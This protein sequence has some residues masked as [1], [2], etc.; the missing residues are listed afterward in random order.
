[1]CGNNTPSKSQ[2]LPKSPANGQ[3]P[4]WSSAAK[5][6]IAADESGSGVNAYLYIAYADDA[7][8]NGFTTAFNPL[9]NYIAI[10]HTSNPIL[11]AQVDF[12]ELW[13]NYKGQKGDKGDPGNN[14]NN[15]AAGADG[16]DGKDGQSAFVYVGYADDENGGGFSEVFDPA[17]QFIAIRHT[18]WELD[19]QDPETFT[20]YWTK[21][22][23]DDGAAGQN[24]LNGQSAYVYIAYADNNI[25]AGFT[26][27][28]NTAKN[29]IAVRN[30]TVP[31]TPVQGDFNGLWFNY[32]GQQGNPGANGADGSNGLNGQSAY[33][34]LGYA[35]DDS[36]AGY[37]PVFDP[38]KQYIAVRSSIVPLTPVQEDF[39][40]LWFKYKG[41]PGL[42]GNPGADG[43]NGANGQSAY[44]Y[45]AYANDAGGSGFTTVFTGAQNFIAVKS[46][47][48]PLV[49]V[50][51][52]FAG[53]WFNYKGEPGTNGING[54]NG[55]NGQSAYVYIA[56][57]DS[58]TGTGF[59]T[60]F[61]AAK[62]YIAIKSSNVPLT[63]LQSDFNGLWFSYKGQAGVNG[64]DG[65]NGTN[66][67][68]G[69][70]AY[71]YIAYA[72]DTEGNGYTPTFDPNKNFIAMFQAT[73]P[74]DISQST[75][76]GLWVQ[77]K[78]GSGGDTPPF[79]IVRQELAEDITLVPANNHFYLYQPNGD[80]RKIYLDVPL[81]SIRFTIK[82]TEP[83]GGQGVL[84]VQDIEEITIKNILMGKSAQ[85]LYDIAAS[86]W[87]VIEC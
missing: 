3:V 49:P 6:W 19:G 24:G 4:K 72:D 40:G 23:G 20:G 82:N 5:A 7:D 9:K 45:I 63:P 1:M 61:N 31:L 71:L 67:L 11:P 28:F 14:G 80:Q 22:K 43:A 78:G 56:Y 60:A 73:E 29:F 12:A 47:T 85:I 86:K 79:T 54:T 74:T 52:D 65:L 44:V 37:T 10:K 53:L 84:A 41:E 55:L 77:Y 69:Q 62:N 39:A 46:S 51:G 68:N 18:T 34:Y 27:A 17:K 33:L 42:N 15:G 57:A 32:K 81:T 21:Y 8:G 58:N 26:T 70:N 35:D 48:V 66:G 2:R 75:F 76:D 64:A 87:E 25:G 13:F 30:S 83:E 38:S 59:T 36:G 16:A 50:Q